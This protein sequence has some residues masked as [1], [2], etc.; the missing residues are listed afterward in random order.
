MGQLARLGL[1]RSGGTGARGRGLGRRRGICNAT[2]ASTVTPAPR[3]LLS[4]L[5]LLL[6]LTPSAPQ[7]YAVASAAPVTPGDPA[8]PATDSVL[9]SVRD[10]LV[11]GR[12]WQ[13]S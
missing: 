12:P 13:A 11:R 1:G 2:P 10:A 7:A 6:A 5:S 4:H 8:P 3:M 9:A